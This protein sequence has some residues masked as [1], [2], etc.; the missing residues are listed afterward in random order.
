VDNARDPAARSVDLGGMATFSAG[1]G[2]LIYALN[3]GPKLGWTQPVEIALLAGALVCFFLFVRIERRHDYPLFDLRLFA[4]P[5]FLGVS[6]VPIASSV[7]YWSLFVYLPLYLDRVLGL[8]A[9]EIGLAMMPF[10]LPMLVVPPFAARLARFVAP[11]YQFAAG[12][13]L[14]A[15]GDWLLARTVH[16][17]P[18]VPLVAPLFIAGLGAGLI[19]AQITSVAVSVVPVARAGTASG[20]SATMRQVGYGL[21]IAGL[22]AV[23]HVA[24]WRSFGHSLSASPTL[25][26]LDANAAFSAFEAGVTA[27]GL[28]DPQLDDAVLRAFSHGMELMLL[29]AGSITLAGAAA[30]FFLVRGCD[31][32]GTADTGAA[33]PT[34]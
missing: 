14:I 21:G 19:N 1:L 33:A 34:E 15:A 16:A 10:T 11:R 24:S 31:I 7:G 26:A 27:S 2:L 5:T 8:P 32:E 4:L 30:A 9:A 28:K 6:L 23:L 20:I 3:A 22:G 29:V 12:L 18:G 13:A 25:A 17:G